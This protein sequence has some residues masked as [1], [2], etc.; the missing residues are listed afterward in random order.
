MKYLFVITST[1]AVC[2]AAQGFALRSVGGRTVKSESNFFSSIGRI[3]AGTRGKVDA[4]ILGSSIT[5]RLPDRAQGYAG[6]ANMGCDGGSAVDALRAM[7]QGILPSAKHLVIEA[8]TL[9]LA[10]EGKSTEIGSA[11]RRPWFRVGTRVPLL[12]A[13]ARPSAFLYSKLLA[14]RIGTFAN[15][16]GLGDLGVAE[17]PMLIPAPPAT[18]LDENQ[19]NLIAELTTILVKFSH[20]GIKTTIVWLPPARK[21]G[22]QPPE[23]ILELARRSGSRY[24]DLG[25]MADPDSI[26]L[27]DGVHMSA[28]SAALTMN[29]LDKVL[30][31]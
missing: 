8:N 26:Q 22:S 30:A 9:Q 13:Y 28:E 7:D 23:W 21:D 16:A 24:W 20:R 11:I 19:E 17:A 15:S 10:L 4:M 25:Q 14:N 3:Q 18:S 12:A 1:L 6:W 2:F 5:G 27:T 31:K 29:S